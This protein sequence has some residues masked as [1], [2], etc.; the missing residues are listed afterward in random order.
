MCPFSQLFTKQFLILK[1]HK[2]LLEAGIQT[3][4]FLGHSIWKGAAVTATANGISKADM[5]L[6]SRWK[7][8]T[9]DV[10]FNEI[11]QSDHIRKLLHLNSQLLNPA[12]L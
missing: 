6:L 10:Y 3:D 9:V 11:K 7:S 12:L 1:I 8:D 4:G 5:K 2:R